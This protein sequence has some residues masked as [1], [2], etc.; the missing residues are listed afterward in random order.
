MPRNPAGVL[1]VPAEA[2]VTGAAATH[3]VPDEIEPG[4]FLL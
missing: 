4:K 3:L 1:C 2:E